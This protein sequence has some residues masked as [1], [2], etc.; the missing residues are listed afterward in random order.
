MNEQ[1]SFL[2]T[3]TAWARAAHEVASLDDQGLG[4]LNGML[5]YWRATLP[6]EVVVLVDVLD[7]MQDVCV[8]VLA[9]RHGST[10][11]EIEKLISDAIARSSDG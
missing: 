5:R 6:G 8:A 1:D 4:A 3:A 10:V 7:R 9:E 11:P 2:A